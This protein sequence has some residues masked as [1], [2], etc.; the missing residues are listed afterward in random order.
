MTKDEILA[1]LRRRQ[2]EI[3]QNQPI[4]IY[5]QKIVELVFDM[6]AEILADKQK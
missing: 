5:F 6:T 1:E 2:A 4:M 3:D